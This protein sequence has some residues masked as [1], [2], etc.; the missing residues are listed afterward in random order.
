LN[1][2]QIAENSTKR[3]RQIETAL[4]DNIKTEKPAAVS[5]A[6]I[7]DIGDDA[8]V[9]LICPTRQVAKAKQLQ[10]SDIET[11]SLGSG[12]HNLRPN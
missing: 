4:A 9:P 1:G 10:H 2:E 6:G 12:R 7:Y 5:G 8:N 11:K 3:F